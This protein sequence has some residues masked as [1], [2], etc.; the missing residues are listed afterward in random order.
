M[1]SVVVLSSVVRGRARLRVP[2]LRRQRSLALLL[3][4]RLGRDDGVRRV[5]A[6][7]ITGNVL[8]LFDA[9]RL[10]IDELRKRIASEAARYHARRRNHPAESERDQLPPAAD[11]PA[12]HTRSAA[13]AIRSLND[14][15]AVG[16]TS[17]EA[18]RRLLASGPNRLPVP[19]P[20]SAFEIVWEQI[21][22]LP[23]LLL[24]GAAV[25]SIATGGLIDGAAILAV[26]AI[27]AAIG[28]TTESRVER[29]LASLKE[30]GVPMAFVRRDGREGLVPRAELAPGDVMLLRPGHDVPADGRLIAAD[31][32]H[33]DESALTGESVAV[34][35]QLKPVASGEAPIADRTNM[36]YAGT[37]VAEGTGEAI[38]TATGRRT[39][40]GRIRTLVSEATAP[41]TPLE[42]QLDQTGRQLAFASLGLCGGLFI[43]GVLRGLPAFGVFRTAASLAVAAVPEGLPTVAT[44]TMALGMRR[45]LERRTLVRRLAAVESLGS[46]TVICV[47]KTG[48]VTENRMTVGRWHVA[49]RDHAQNSLAPGLIDPGLAE[50]ITVAVLCNEATL[51]VKEDGALDTRG[52]ATEISL[53]VAA[54]AAGVDS[55]VLRERHPL[56][57]MSPRADGRNWMGS[58]H[59]ADGHRL[60]AVKGAPEEVLRVCTRWLRAEGEAALDGADRRRILSANDRMADEGMRVLG[61]AFTRIEAEASARWDALTWIGLVGLIDPIRPGVAEAIAI[62]HQA[63][64]RPV[65]ITGDQGLTA[66]AV[67]RKL[68]LQ[69]NGQLRMLEAGEL[70]RLDA[71]AMRGVVREVDVFARVA[72]AQKYEIVRAL[73]AGGDVVAMTGDG[74]NDGP[75]LKAADI[76]VAMGERGT[77]MARDIADVVLMDDDFGAIV[78]AVEHGRTLR[79]NLRKAL[80]FLLATNLSEV[81][82]TGIAML[83]GRAQPLS[84]LHLLWINLVTDV[85]PALALGMEPA[86]PGVM[87]QPPPAPGTALLGRDAVVTMA[88]DAAVMAATTLGAFGLTLARSGDGARASTVAFSTL[89]GGQ[90]LYAL[91]CRSEAQSGLRR[92]R[93][94]PLLLAGV[95]GMLVL[96][97]AT[98]V[99]PPL[100]T[101]LRTAPLGLADLALIGAGSVTPLL[102]REALKTLR[103]DGRKEGGS[104]G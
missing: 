99:A 23:T 94:S 61:L 96:Q 59:A 74:V 87:G 63:G 93:D 44:T 19:Q 103:S 51:T 10:E 41:R 81:L 45:M 60:V 54:R 67:G 78:A 56:L 50:A 38:V 27:N 104:R 95:G 14:T 5:Q 28:Y 36:V 89:G 69:R 26:I 84:A 75:A 3:Q 91:T 22:S 49:G 2:G 35:K 39:E 72:P 58:L 88:V 8:V 65:M 33:A 42:R 24:G 100:R 37:V 53:L 9:D 18:E 77:E 13:Q 21:G 62:C 76:G 11:G 31:R 68:G 86:E 79:A 16:L 102:V 30:V 34:A 83:V 25:A 55:R 15:P 66:V 70:A 98:L 47:D 1:A 64:I 17:Q 80:R 92:L 4:D 97:A 40:L 29:L 57:A 82:V 32:L 46:T 6:S 101:L 71:S 12:W 52:S 43:V 90:L 85:V 48:T 7:E 20:K 73:Q